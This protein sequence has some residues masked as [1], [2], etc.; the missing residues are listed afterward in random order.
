MTRDLD[1]HPQTHHPAAELLQ[2][3]LTLLYFWAFAV[4][5]LSKILVLWNKHW[6]GKLRD[7]METQGEKRKLN[8][9][10]VGFLDQGRDTAGF[11]TISLICNV[12]MQLLSC[13][14]IG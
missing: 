12:K 10:L 5:G 11:C 7:V 1:F 4:S 2:G 6:T 3:A 13:E 9:L 14:L 8:K